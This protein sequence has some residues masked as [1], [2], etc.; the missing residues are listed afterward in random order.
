MKKFTNFYTANKIKKWSLPALFFILLISLLIYSVYFLTVSP[1][2]DDISRG[3][4]VGRLSAQDIAS[5]IANTSKLAKLSEEKLAVIFSD[6]GSLSFDVYDKMLKKKRSI[7]TGIKNV[8]DFDVSGDKDLLSLLYLQDNVLYQSIYNAEDADF[9]ETKKLSENA[10]FVKSAGGYILYNQADKLMVNTPKG[11]TINIMTADVTQAYIRYSKNQAE[12]VVAAAEESDSSIYYIKLQDEKVY[13]FK[14]L[15]QVSTNSYTKIRHVMIVPSE[16]SSDVLY[17]VRDNKSKQVAYYIIDNS[18]TDLENVNSSNIS[19]VDNI[20]KAD[21][22]KDSD[23]HIK[24]KNL[25]FLQQDSKPFIIS[26][27]P[28]KILFTKVED[29]GNKNYFQIAEMQYKDGEFTDEK[30]LTK[31]RISAANP[32]LIELSG[33]S[34]LKYES[35]NAFSKDV[36]L[37]SSNP[38]I[39]E[40][41]SHLMKGEMKSVF[42]DSLSYA[43]FAYAFSLSYLGYIFIFAA[44]IFFSS[45]FFFVGWTERNPHILMM[46]IAAAHLFAAI[47]TLNTYLLNT[48]NSM[49]LPEYLTVPLIPLTLTTLSIAAGLWIV[50]AGYDKEQL[51]H[52]LWEAYFQFFAV[53][54][55][56][57]M[58]IYFP[59][60]AY[61]Y[62]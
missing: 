16:N 61:N 27:D 7:D 3:F 10:G 45:M 44:L 25:S 15:T 60:L 8:T 57:Y 40:K 35:V 26:S 24:I 55:V 53:S 11:N 48:Q 41:S 43:A 17:S 13:N 12:I 46:I 28:A 2:S 58:L 19:D 30:M 6:N 5:N 62:L 29:K 22:S 32:Q 18:E 1:P 47:L 31:G 37:A 49:N 9:I 54:S 38:D 52:R 39:I 23:S 36:Y 51:K 50:F 34:Y 42:T 56:L 21:N 14:T 59:F 20:S 4:A 33:N